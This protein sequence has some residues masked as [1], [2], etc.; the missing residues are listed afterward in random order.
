MSAQDDKKVRGIVWFGFWFLLLGFSVYMFQT[1]IDKERNPNQAPQTLTDTN[2]R[3]VVLKRNR[4]GH[5]HATGYI[6]GTQ[7]EF[8]LDTGATDISIPEHI[9][10][11]LGL[12]KLYPIDIITANGRAKAYGTKIDT[13]EIGSIKL[14]DLNASIN[15]NVDDNTVLLGMSF[16][17][18][19]EF[20]Q[21]GDTLILK[22]YQ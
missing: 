16:L 8:L 4:Q 15:P 21:R 14:N 13:A 2:S 6:N 17:K 18:Q 5:Y 7:L 12:K 22:Q 10:D 1:W 3:Q 20:T 19:I 11:K 9:A